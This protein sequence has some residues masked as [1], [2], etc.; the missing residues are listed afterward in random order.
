M[1]EWTK[2]ELKDI[3]EEV[4]RVYQN[5]VSRHVLV[6][7]RAD[8]RKVRLHRGMSG[9]SLNAIAAELR[10]ALG[11]ALRKPPPEGPASS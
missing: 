1:Q 8:G 5:D 2:D 11:L 3:R 9:R 4:T 10:I 6:F 7:E